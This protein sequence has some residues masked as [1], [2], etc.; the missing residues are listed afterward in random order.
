MSRTK[1]PLTEAELEASHQALLD[2]VS[3]HFV[4]TN[5]VARGITL[6]S[7]ENKEDAVMLFALSVPLEDADEMFGPLKNMAEHYTK[8]G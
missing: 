1:P 7:R 2:A 8:R 3:K 4:D 5:A 6:S